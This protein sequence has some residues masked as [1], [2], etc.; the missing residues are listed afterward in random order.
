MNSKKKISKVMLSKDML[1]KMIGITINQMS[2]E[3]KYEQV[4]IK[5]GMK[6]HGQK[7]IYAILAKFT[8]QNSKGVLKPIHVCQLTGEMKMEPLNLITLVQE[9]R[10]D[11]GK[12]Q[13]CD[14]GYKQR[15]FINKDGVS[16]PTVQLES[17][18]LSLLVD[19]YEKRD[20]ATSDVMYAYL[21]TIM[22]YF[23]PVKLNAKSIQ[24]MCKVNSECVQQAKQGSLIS[25]IV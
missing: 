8:E 25:K 24:I 16:S 14:D 9:K 22:D 20:V 5:E 13:S 6:R 18:M 10:N 2:K 19:A 4:S 21:M 17:L 23:V 15:R 11:K 1:K 7:A 12:G 3:E